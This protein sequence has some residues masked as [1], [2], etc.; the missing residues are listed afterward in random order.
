VRVAM[1]RPISDT[2]FPCWAMWARCSL[3]KRM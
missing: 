3:F 2:H 1:R